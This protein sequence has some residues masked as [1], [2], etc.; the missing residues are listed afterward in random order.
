MFINL[1]LYFFSNSD[2]TSYTK[3]KEH[4]HSHAASVVPK[5]QI[6]KVLPIHTAINNAKRQLLGVYYKIKPEY[7]QYYLNQL[8]YK[9]NRR[10]LGENL[11]DRLM[12]ASV[13]AKNEFRRNIR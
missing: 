7:L 5:V 6:S 11:F 10:Y 4:V 1:Y 8:C 9:F 13:V 12:V 3:L 2:S